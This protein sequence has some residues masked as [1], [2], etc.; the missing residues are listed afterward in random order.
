MPCLTLILQGDKA[1][2]MAV[3]ERERETETLTTNVSANESLLQ[4]LTSQLEQLKI[5]EL[6]IQQKAEEIPTTMWQMVM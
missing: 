5:K 4:K 3:D 6:E 1:L 2:E